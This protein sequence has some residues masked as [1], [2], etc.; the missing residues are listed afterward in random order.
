MP[1]SPHGTRCAVSV[2]MD[3]PVPPES[4]LRDWLRKLKADS[5]ASYAAIAQAIGEEE[6]T[7]KRWM[8]E[9][10]AARVV[11]PRGDALLKLLDFFGVTI[12]P[13][14]PRAVALSLLGELRLVREEILH[15]S[16]EAA[17]EV[18]LESVDRHLQELGD[19]VSEA[20]RLLRVLAAA[21]VPGQAPG[22]EAA[23]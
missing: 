20:V 19:R 2:P 21:Q 12:S 22:N 5:G 4:E 6:R 18:S 11:V 9:K 15:G 3:S 13:P 17:G 7:V 1:L 16:D 14:A 10:P 8:P 23:R